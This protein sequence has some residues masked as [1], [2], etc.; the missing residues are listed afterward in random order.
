MESI[1]IV[2][3]LVWAFLIWSMLGFIIAFCTLFFGDFNK[4][5]PNKRFAF[6]ILI[7]PVGLPLLVVNKLINITLKWFTE[8]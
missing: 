3:I 8:Y 6:Y 5:A 2:G 1:V 7:G 4:I